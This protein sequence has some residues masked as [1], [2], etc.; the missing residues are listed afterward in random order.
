MLIAGLTGGTGSGKSTVA[1]RFEAHGIAIVDADRVGHALIEAGGRA[2]ADVLRHF[3][4]SILACGIIDRG[5]LG[6][7]VFADAEALSA[8]NRIMKPMIAESI[9]MKCAAFAEAGKAVT[10]VDAALLGDSGSVEPWIEG[11]ILVA[12]PA[13]LRARRLVESRGLSEAQAMQR[14]AAQVDPERKRP[15]ARWIIEN[16]GSLEALHE[17]A[18]GVARELLRLSRSSET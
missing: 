5:K 1:R 6:A 8:L 18:D 14:I 15:L 7:L 12:C 17:Q 10:V 3:G 13:E 2:E 4:P 16:T 9:A 11:L